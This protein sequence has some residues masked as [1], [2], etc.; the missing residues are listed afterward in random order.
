MASPTR[1][2]SERDGIRR[3][4]DRA[5]RTLLARSPGYAALPP[6]KRRRLAADI[7]TVAKHAAA[8]D[9]ARAVDAVDFPAFVAGLVQGVFQAVVDA[10]IQQMKAYAA[11]VDGVARAVEAAAAEVRG[12][13]DEARR[14][15][16]KARQQQL[17]TMVLLGI[18]RIVVTNGEIRA[19][20]T[21][22]VKMDAEGGGDAATA[23]PRELQRPSKP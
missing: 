4:V 6:N 10:S 20:V 22:A 3:E 17:A 14:S 21:F 2:S 12:A 19:K 8:H 23:R 5:V 1:S 7:V 13:T 11:L 15:L 16:A 18:N 9:A